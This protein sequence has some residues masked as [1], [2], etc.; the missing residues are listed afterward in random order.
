MSQDW[1]RIVLRLKSSS[2]YEYLKAQNIGC[3]LR[4]KRFLMTGKMV[5]KGQGERFH[6]PEIAKL[7]NTR[8]C[9]TRERPSG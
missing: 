4:C 7:C 3:A 8:L 6:V 9:N 2:Y 5:G 1:F